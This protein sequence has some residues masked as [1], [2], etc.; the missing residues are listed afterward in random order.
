[1]EIKDKKYRIWMWSE[2]AEQFRPSQ[3]PLASSPIEARAIGN[4]NIK[5]EDLRQ[6]RKGFEVRPE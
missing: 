2:I 4:A 1:M 3:W 5:Q 6:G